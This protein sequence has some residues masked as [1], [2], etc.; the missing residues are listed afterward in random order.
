MIAD[1]IIIAFEHP[2][3]TGMITGGCAIGAPLAIIGWCI[4]HDT[5]MRKVGEWMRPPKDDAHGDVP[6]LPPVRE[7]RFIPTVGRGS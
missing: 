7:R 5:A 2:F 1:I 6:N 3:V 4:G